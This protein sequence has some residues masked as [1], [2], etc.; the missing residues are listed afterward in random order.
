MRCRM[1]NH[2]KSSW[3]IKTALALNYILFAM[4][5]NSIGPVI[6][7]VQHYFGATKAQA[8][9]LDACHSVAAITVSILIAAQL[10][11][12]GCRR[13]MLFALGIIAVVC[14][15]IPS[16]NSF[17]AFKLLFAATGAGFAVIKMTGMT[18]IG[19]I[20]D[21][22]KSHA[23]LMAF[24]G[25]FFSAGVFLGYFLFAA[26]IDEFDPL[27]PD[28]LNVYYALAAIAVIA[29]V[30]LW[31]TPI[32][33]TAIR[34]T[35]TKP[36]LVGFK[37]ILLLAATTLTAVYGA[38]A[39]TYV[40]IEHS[41]MSWLPTFNAQVLHL[42][43]TLSIQMASILAASM[44]AGRF[45]AA[46]VLRT[47]SWLVVLLVCLGGAAILVLVALPLATVAPHAP[48][49]ATWLDA[50]IAAFI[51]PLIGLFL[52]PIN[53]VLNSVILTTLPV[54]RH[55]TMAGLIMIFTALGGASGAITMAF[56]FQIYGGQAA[57]YFSLV[58]MAVSAG[59][60]IFLRHL[61]KAH[62]LG[63]QSPVTPEAAMQKAR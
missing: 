21:S 3:R 16:L 37:E 11:R 59:L 58:P 55:G 47:V 54:R 32:D 44:T 24:L 2:P 51:F 19:L 12:L 13:A 56:V 34:S 60:L 31:T 49:P 7:Q 23:S 45:I 61:Q 15:V 35:E 41:I 8:S 17:A 63:R 46:Y 50:P 9:I 20:T 1:T 38:C 4:L 57:F 5:M 43:T 25:G 30:L 22:E 42:P 26:F 28:W 6:L 40:L 48:S 33:E 14:A 27:S 39:F 62:S 53:Q 18:T 52:A 10:P 29:F 36:L